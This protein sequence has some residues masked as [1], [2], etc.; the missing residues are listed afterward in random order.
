MPA[1]RCWSSQNPGSPIAASSSTMRACRESGSKVI[2]DPV[3]LGPD[4]LEL[5][6]QR[7]RLLGHGPDG[8][9]LPGLLGSAPEPLQRARK[10]IGLD[11]VRR[12]E[13]MALLEHL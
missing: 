4:L 10:A 5:L 2:T 1:A 9:W 7:E 12:V 11:P 6:L 13:V 8:S 3:E